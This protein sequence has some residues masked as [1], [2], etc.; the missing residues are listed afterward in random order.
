MPKRKEHRVVNGCERKYCRIC[1]E[2]KALGAYYK[3]KREADGLNQICS[4]CESAKKQ[5]PRYAALNAYRLIQWRVNDDKQNY[6]NKG[7]KCLIAKEAFLDWYIPKHFKGCR[8]DRKD[9]QGHYEV[10]NM[11]LISL[12]DHNSKLRDD[13]LAKHGAS[14]TATHRFCSSCLKMV[15]NDSY[16]IKARKVS[17]SNPL[18]LDD[19]CKECAKKDRRD[20][21]KRI[22]EGDQHAFPL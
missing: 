6:I 12:A 4:V 15:S 11:Q 19:K 14:D 9:N 3:N 21:Y 17:I 18:G 13:N 16:Y 7:I 5:T 20:H 1:G 10:G 2:W 8:V 22:K